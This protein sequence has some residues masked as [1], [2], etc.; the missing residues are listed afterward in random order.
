MILSS[1][2]TQKYL[3]ELFREKTRNRVREGVEDWKESIGKDENKFFSFA[4]D[5][6]E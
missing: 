5:T 1:Y 2:V 6:E 4:L 3:Q